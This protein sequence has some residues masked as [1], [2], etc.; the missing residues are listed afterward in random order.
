MTP[1]RLDALRGNAGS[2]DLE[3]SAVCF[4]QVIL[5]N[6]LPGVGQQRLM[7]DMDAWGYSFR[8]GTTKCWFDDDADDFS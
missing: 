4:L 3:E 8:K 7:Q 6:Y 2:D 5:A 1:E